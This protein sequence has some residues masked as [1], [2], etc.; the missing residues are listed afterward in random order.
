MIYKTTVRVQLEEIN[1]GSWPGRFSTL[2]L[3]NSLHLPQ[4]STEAEATKSIGDILSSSEKFLGLIDLFAF[5]KQSRDKSIRHSPL[6]QNSESANVPEN[7]IITS[8]EA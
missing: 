5:S 2:S 4:G 6:P 7:K 1:V 3:T 8:G